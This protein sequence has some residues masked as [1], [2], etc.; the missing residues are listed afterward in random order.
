MKVA[1]LLPSTSIHTLH[2][3]QNIWWQQ[4]N[5]GG[6]PEVVQNGKQVLL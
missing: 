3:G 6:L 2:N 5:V 1:I 4:G